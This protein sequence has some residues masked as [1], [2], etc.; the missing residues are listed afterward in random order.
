MTVTLLKSNYFELTN[1]QADLTLIVGRIVIF[2][3]AERSPLTLQQMISPL[4]VGTLLA[5][6]HI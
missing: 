4:R 6:G 2:T 5:D 1:R 3:L